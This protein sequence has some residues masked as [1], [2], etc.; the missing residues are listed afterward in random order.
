MCAVD[1]IMIEQG[2]AGAPAIQ[3]PSAVQNL[4]DP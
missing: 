2:G 1:D 4:T 3:V